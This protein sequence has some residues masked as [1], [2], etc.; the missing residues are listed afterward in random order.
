MKIG[1]LPADFSSILQ[2]IGGE[3][4]YG[5]WPFPG[6]GWNTALGL[7]NTLVM[8]IIPLAIITFCYGTIMWKLKQRSHLSQSGQSGTHRKA[9]KNVTITFC[10][11]ALAYI[12]CNI[13]HHV[14]FLMF[15]LG[16]PVNWYGNYWN[17]VVQMVF[18]NCTIN[19]FIYMLKS[20]DFQRAVRD[21][22][23]M[24]RTPSNR[25]QTPPASISSI[26]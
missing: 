22:F 8:F 23:C 26:S 20:R 5:S 17:F 2:I 1:I 18:L 6:E 12:V 9:S 10:L 21:L 13:Q 3:C 7:L 14:T 24:N 15:N 16:Y 11:V 19:P 4:L 25:S